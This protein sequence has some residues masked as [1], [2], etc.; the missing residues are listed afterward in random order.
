[1]KL[2]TLLILAL[3]APARA[4]TNLYLAAVGPSEPQIYVGQPFD[5]SVGIGTTA[6]VIAVDYDVLGPVLVLSQN[7]SGGPFAEAFAADPTIAGVDLGAITPDLSIV[8]GFAVVSTLTVEVPPGT[9][10][11]M[12]T[13]SLAS[14]S[15]GIGWTSPS[16]ADNPFDSMGSMQVQVVPEPST[17]CIGLCAV[18]YVLLLRMSR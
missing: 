15:A 18:G 6:P 14:V 3:A 16:F 7:V 11:G 17:A 10:P 1:M 4:V 5:I 9:A 12:Y 13:I 2:L 8:N